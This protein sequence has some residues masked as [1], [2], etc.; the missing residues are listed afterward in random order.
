MSVEFLCPCGKRRTTAEAAGGQGQCP[1]C[2]RFLD[3]PTIEPNAASPG[4]FSVLEDISTALTDDPSG[5][6]HSSTAVT[7]SANDQRG[8]K[9]FAV[10]ADDYPLLARPAYRLASPG[11]IG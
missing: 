2:G 10:Q 6:P 4:T 1:A 8:E 3:I 7:E 9:A 5:Q 11:Q